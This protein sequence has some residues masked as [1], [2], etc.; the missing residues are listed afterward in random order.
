MKK[1]TIAMLVFASMTAQ[2]AIYECNVTKKFDTENIY[3]KEAIERGKFS[4]VVKDT[5][6]PT[7]SRCSFTPSKAAITCDEYPVDKIA[8]AQKVGIK[9]YYYFE[10]QLDVQLYPP[11]GKGE[12]TFVE[13]N[14]RG[15]IAFG[16][17][18]TVK[19]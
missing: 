18:K 5:A 14:G 4:V 3:S 10:G 11:V 7:I 12:M 15:G 6:S 8:Q 19:P 17:C 1:I 9:K 16:T 13:N 2:A